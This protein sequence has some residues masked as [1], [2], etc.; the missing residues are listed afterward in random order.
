[1]AKAVLSDIWSRGKLPVIA[2]GS[3]LFIKGILEPLD[4]MNIPP[5]WVLRKHIEKLSVIELVKFLINIDVRRYKVMNAS[6]RLNPRRLIRAIEIAQ[7]LI[8]NKKPKKAKTLQMDL[9]IVGLKTAKEDL[10]IK[11]K[12]RMIKRVKDGAEEEVKSL[13]QKGFNFDNSVLGYTIGYKEWRGFFA[14]T[15]TREKVFDDWYKAEC[16]YA[17]RKNVWFKK[18]KKIKWFDIKENNYQLMIE[19]LVDKWYTGNN[20]PICK[21]TG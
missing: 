9:L 18:Q 2:G 14:G 6:D 16:A 19:K 20:L 15:K 7:Y 3:G 8:K 1:L 5:D 10:Y 11:I 21:I 17:K 13:L 4:F 12:E